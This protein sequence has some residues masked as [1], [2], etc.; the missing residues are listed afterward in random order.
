MLQP[1]PHTHKKLTWHQ[2]RRHLWRDRYIY[3]MVIPVLVYLAIM[4]Y[5][6]MW[7][8]RIS[9]YDYKLLKGF[10]GSKYVGFKWFEQMLGN[11][12]TFQYIANTLVLN[13]EALLIVF[14]A[15]IVFALLLNE[16]PTPRLKKWVQSTSYL[17]YFLSMVVLTAMISVFVSPSIGTLASI[18]KALGGKPVHYLADPKYFRTILILSGLW[19]GVGYNAVVYLSALTAIDGSLYEAA[20]IDGAGRFK[21]VWHVT[22]PCIAPTIIL[23][24]IL[25]IG[26]MMQVNFEKVFLLQNNMNLSVSEMLPTYIYKMGIQK[27]KYSFATATG[28]FNSI[29]SLILV[30]S[31]NFVSRKVS[32]TSLF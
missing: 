15:P 10:E 29:I 14:P 30:V 25:Q 8:L 22:L 28:L 13:V 27:Q 23:L 11:P 2:L 4:K 18:T 1:N 21:R 7:Y 5:W 26:N 32:E 3:M 12:E 16:M 20:T 24:L 6:P 19:Q 17:P 9:F 31:A